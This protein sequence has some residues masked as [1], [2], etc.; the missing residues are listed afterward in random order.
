MWMR[1]VKA[2][3]FAATQ[4]SLFVL[5]QIPCTRDAFVR[6]KGV[7]WHVGMWGTVS[8]TPHGVLSV[9]IC[10]WLLFIA[11]LWPR[12]RPPSVFFLQ[13]LLMMR[14]H[15]DAGCEGTQFVGAWNVKETPCV[16][17]SGTMGYEGQRMLG[18]IGVEAKQVR[19][20]DWTYYACGDCMRET[21]V[22]V[23]LGCEGT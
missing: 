9:L 15:V 13:V 7:A 16:R 20:L 23:C 22:R 19:L 8:M 12:P 6:A 4:A 18:R 5:V 1:D 10:C 11:A 3:N 14:V 17:L 21:L 2:F